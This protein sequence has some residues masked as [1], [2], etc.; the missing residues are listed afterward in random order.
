MNTTVAY[1]YLDGGVEMYGHW[2]G[3]PA[4]AL[5]AAVER[6]DAREVDARTWRYYAEEDDAWFRE[7]G[8]AVLSGHDDVGTYS[9]W[10]AEAG[11]EEATA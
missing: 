9:L 1:A 10:C 3:N 2:R 4:D 6:L 5:A 11:E 8:A 7:L